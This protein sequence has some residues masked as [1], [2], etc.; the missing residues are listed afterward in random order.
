MGRWIRW[1]VDRGGVRT[2]DVLVDPDQ[3]YEWQPA[4]FT[5]QM[6]LDLAGSRCALAPY[7]PFAYMASPVH[8]TWSP[9]AT[10]T[11]YGDG[12]HPEVLSGD[13]SGLSW[14]A[15]GAFAGF[16]LGGVWGY[17]WWWGDLKNLPSTP[18]PEVASPLTQT[19]VKT[20]DAQNFEVD[21]YTLNAEA[22]QMVREFAATYRLNMQNPRLPGGQAIPARPGPSLTTWPCL[23]SA[24]NSPTNFWKRSWQRPEDSGTQPARAGLWRAKRCRQPVNV[25]RISPPGRHGLNG[26]TLLA[27]D[28]Q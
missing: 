17:M 3:L 21:G 6:R 15:S 5:G 19:Q 18:P 22:R 7:N 25:K 2:N 16:E 28:N 8:H 26:T 9:I 10:V 23:R 20:G 27:I 13:A 11:F 1:S 24:L 4:N 14:V 12:T